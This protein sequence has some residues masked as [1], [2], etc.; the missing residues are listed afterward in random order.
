MM[1]LEDA[2]NKTKKCSTVAKATVPPSLGQWSD[3]EGA[4][5]S[6]GFEV[7]VVSWG[8]ELAEISVSS[9]L[10]RLGILERTRPNS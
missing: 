2:K 7:D 1:T 9:I 10:L 3:K 6:I 5:F 8:V 4:V